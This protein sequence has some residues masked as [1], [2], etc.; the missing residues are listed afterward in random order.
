MERVSLAA[1]S[2]VRGISRSALDPSGFCACASPGTCPPSRNCPNPGGRGGSGKVAA[3]AAAAPAPTA[4]PGPILRGGVSA[5]SS[6]DALPAPDGGSGGCRSLLGKKP[7]VAPCAHVRAGGPGGEDD[8]CLGR[9]WRRRR[10]CGAAGGRGGDAA[11]AASSAL[12]CCSRGAA[13]A[14]TVP[15]SAP[16]RPAPRP[17]AVGSPAFGLLPAGQGLQAP[18][19]R[20]SGCRH[21]AVRRHDQR[22]LGL[23]ARPGLPRPRRGLRAGQ[24]RRPRSAPPPPRFGGAWR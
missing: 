16:R 22:G 19:R 8:T 18:R 13:G 2:M 9:L 6:G 17:A 11:S 23:S 5:A 7:Q 1:V 4:V 15:P 3:A 24:R 12:P 21:I 20:S 14:G 10:R